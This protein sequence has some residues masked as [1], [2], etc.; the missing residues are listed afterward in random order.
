[1]C[2]LV[3]AVAT[4]DGVRWIRSN[5]RTIIIRRKL[6]KLQ[7]NLREVPICPQLF[8]HEMCSTLRANSY[9]RTTLVM[10][11]SWRMPSS[12]MWHHFGIL[13]MEA[14]HS[15]ETSVYNQPRQHH[16]Q[17]DGILHS[18]R[19]ANLKSYMYWSCLYIPVLCHCYREVYRTEGRVIVLR[20]DG[21]DCALPLRGW[22]L[23]VETFA[24][25]MY[26]QTS[27]HKSNVNIGGNF[28]LEEVCITSSA[29]TISHLSVQLP[30][31]ADNNNITG[32]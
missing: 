1:M 28:I 21:G 11:R 24:W 13:K 3:I 9:V 12:G 26:L 17:Y 2:C 7:E 20:L 14:T 32:Q 16:I 15:S 10:Y 29:E 6:K 23:L 30:A 18:H 5:C 31:L 8:S 25:R 27:H 19:R 4:W 22:R